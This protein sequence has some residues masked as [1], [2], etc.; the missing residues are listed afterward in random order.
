MKEKRERKRERRKIKRE[1][2]KTRINLAKIGDEHLELFQPKNNALTLF[3][4]KVALE[5]TLL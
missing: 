4:A 1:R 3:I 5:R 2:R